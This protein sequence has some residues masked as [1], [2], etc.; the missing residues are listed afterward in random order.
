MKK[1][2]YANLMF[3]LLGKVILIDVVLAVAVGLVSFVLDWRT[4]ETYGTA[5]I[6][7]G[8]IV[9]FLAAFIGIGGY[10]ARAGDA[11]AYSPRFPVRGICLKI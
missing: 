9:M 4:V 11:G 5:L 1:Q 10:S 6:R 2:G 3:R 7:T 8:V